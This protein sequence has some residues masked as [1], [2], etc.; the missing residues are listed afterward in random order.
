MFVEKLKFD[1][2]T[3]RKQR[4]FTSNQILYFS[5]TTFT[6]TRPYSGGLPHLRDSAL[7]LAAVRRFHHNYQLFCRRE[8]STRDCLVSA[9]NRD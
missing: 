8:S 2:S 5:E 6:M 7:Q 4:K 3:T 9:K 1:Y